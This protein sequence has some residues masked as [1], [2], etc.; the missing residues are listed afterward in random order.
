MMCVPVPDLL[1]WLPGIPSSTGETGTRINPVHWLRGTE[2]N[3]TPALHWH[4]LSKE[5]MDWKQ[6]WLL[7]LWL[8]LCLKKHQREKLDR[9]FQNISGQWPTW[10][11]NYFPFYVIQ[12]N[13]SLPVS[14]L[15][16]GKQSGFY[17][18]ISASTGRALSKQLIWSLPHVNNLCKHKLMRMVKNSGRYGLGLLTQFASTYLDP[19]SSGLLWWSTDLTESWV[20]FKQHSNMF[21]KEMSFWKPLPPLHKFQ[22]YFTSVDPHF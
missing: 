9:L 5:T 18:G 19:S 4:A 13:R 2:R 17:F 11:W 22:V 7:T 14:A 1:L 16:L 6:S 3:L 15:N 20:P 8:C 21:E 10:E 12:N